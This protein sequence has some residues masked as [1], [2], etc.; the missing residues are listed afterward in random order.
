M[1]ESLIESE[2]FGHEK[3]SFTGAIQ[4]RI[5]RFEVGPGRH[6]VPRRDRQPADLG[7]RRSSCACSRAGSSNASAGANRFALDV[8]VVAATNV[9]LEEAIAAGR[10]RQD[11]YF[12]LQEVTIHLP[13]LRERPGDIARLA[14]HFVAMYARRSISPSRASPSAALELLEAHPWPG[15]ARE[16]E[17]AMKSAV[18]TG[19]RLR[20]AGGFALVDRCP[21]TSE[22]RDRGP[23][24]RR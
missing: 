5:G 16:L 6:A 24:R 19:E 14:N 13:P 4:S 2:L 18:D 7:S 20:P 9:D 11:L 8:R 3:G 1:A 23:Q 21:Q 10:F 22:S 15:N 12:R 17:N